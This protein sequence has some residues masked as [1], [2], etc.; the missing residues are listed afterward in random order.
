MTVYTKTMMEALA[1][2][3]EKDARQ[4]VDPKVEIDEIVPFVAGG[5]AVARAVVPRVVKAIAK[6]V[7]KK[8]TTSAGTAAVV[9]TK[10]A[11]EVELDEDNMDLMRKAVS[12][13]MQTL[14]MKDGKLKMDKVT[15]SAI[16][17]IF[18]KVNP[19][20][21]KK[22]AKMINDGK[23]SGIIKLSDFAMSKV[24]GFKREDI[25]LDEVHKGSK[26]VK[27]LIDPKKEI[28]V[29]KKNKVV[30][31]DKKDQDEY[32]KQGW[33]IAEEVEL[34]E[35]TWALPE[36]PKEVAELKKLLRKSIKAKD[37]IKIVGKYIGD[38]ELFDELGDLKDDDP[39]Q[40]VRPTIKSAM[41][42]LGI[43][44]E[45]AKIV[46]EQLAKIRGNTPADKGRRAAVED[47]IERA[48]KKGDKKEVAK[49][50]EDE[51]DEGRMK[52]L[53]G[54]I[55]AGKSA[56]WI[57]KKM[58]V[59]VK[60]IKT[61]MSEAYELGTDE[62]REYIEK[63]TPGE[64]DEA[65]LDE[66]TVSDVEIAMKKK[67]GKID[68][69]AIEKLK[70]V[71]YKG[72]VDRNDLVKVGH[73]KL[74]V[75]EVEIDEEVKVG[76]TVKVKLHRK[77]QVYIESGKVISIDA[78]NGTIDV[79][80]S[81]SNR[82]SR[83][84]MSDIVKEEVEID[85]ASARADAMK[86][87]RKGKEVDPADVDIDASP[88]DIKGASKN[89]IMQMRKVVSMRGNFVVEFGDKKKEKIPAAV[90]QAVQNKY[91]SF[92]KPADKEK[93]Q[94]QVGKSYKDMLRV[95][96]A[97]YEEETE[98]DEAGEH[99]PELYGIFKSKASA[100]K[101]AIAAYAK[102]RDP[103]DKIEV[104]Q[105]RGNK[106][107]INH[108]MNSSG[109]DFI[110]KRGGK[111]I[112]R[113]GKNFKEEVEIDEEKFDYTIVAIKNKKVVAQ[114][115]SISKSELKAAIKLFKKISP[116]AKISIEDKGGKIVHTE[117]VDLDEKFTKKDYDEN[118]D[119]NMHSENAVELARKFG[120]TKEYNRMVAIYK[121]H[122]KRG[123]I[124][125]SDQKERDKLVNKYYPKLESVMRKETIL[126]RIDKKLKEKKEILEASNRWELAGKKFS[127]VNDKGTFILVPQGRAGKEQKLKA[128]TTQD[129]TQE[130]VKKGYRES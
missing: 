115:H 95:L 73:G 9:G 113:V 51:L 47:D 6:R 8:V 28:M 33:T 121:A 26:G 23:K 35:G 116:D 17:Q 40:D 4:L 44:E 84:S 79:K 29:V 94:A 105:T 91:N 18:D 77:G 57:A 112:A 117:E 66:W 97:G 2:V 22:M 32:L 72:N 55:E 37:A 63:L 108:P 24:T 12:G 125:S 56:E 85:E 38:D 93:F 11:E 68:K 80:H 62:Y 49:L 34:D 122:M 31:I 45:I 14:K 41:K 123:S 103:L 126:E 129:A 92:K 5:L 39:N 43:K 109:R 48:K 86:A 7:G 75:E 114:L 30:V 65:D 110:Q 104:W 1:E 120:S 58:G 119:N 90:A 46:A 78:K 127:L 98:L 71:Q 25:D 82:P 83:V 52:E 102:Q 15:A 118:E 64:V 10:K 100:T 59:D 74:Y 106:F 27:Q 16:M 19:A 124:S 3:R 42:R 60:T 61:L 69:E 36:T 101:A 67:Y 76:Q 70:K 99:I 50:K 53:Y 89:I 88:E 21:Q 13:A 54:Y 20:N 96:K 130:L 87:M 111:L 107:E 81:F 128:K